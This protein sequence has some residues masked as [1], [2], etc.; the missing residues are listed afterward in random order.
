MIASKIQEL[1]HTQRIIT[2]GHVY[3]GL[4]INVYSVTR[5][6]KVAKFV[7]TIISY[8]LTKFCV[9]RE[10]V[11]LEIIL[12]TPKNVSVQIVLEYQFKI[13]TS[14]EIHL[15]ATNVLTIIS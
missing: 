1:A 15:T 7:M 5:E 13:A 2:I 10:V 12:A 14:V 4:L 8:S 6:R 11:Q 3:S 9:F